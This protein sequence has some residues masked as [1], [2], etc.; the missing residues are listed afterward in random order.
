MTG[1]WRRDN[2]TSRSLEIVARGLG[3]RVLVVNLS[4]GTPN[5]L[6]TLILG[7]ILQIYRS[8]NLISSSIELF[9]RS[10]VNKLKSA[11]YLTALVF[12]LILTDSRSAYGYIDPSTGSYFLQILL[13]GLLGGLFA[14][15]VYWRNVKNYL[16]RMFSKGDNQQNDTTC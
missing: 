12:L 14:L 1:R 6:E 16:S 4:N 11:A 5:M 7:Q 8:N 9:W 15:K 13:A 2:L 3:R 10:N